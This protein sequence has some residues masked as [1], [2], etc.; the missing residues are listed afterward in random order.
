MDIILLQDVENLG[1][2]DDVVKVKPGYARNFLIPRNMA[3]VANR[4]NTK[5]LEEKLRQTELK[6]QKLLAEYK[7]QA[8]KIEGAT[9][10][11]G[12][13]VGTS[14]K[15]FGSITNIQVADAIKNT[16]GVE[17]DRKRL[18]LQDEIKSLGTYKARVEL[19]KDVSLEFDFE[20]IAE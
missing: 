20:V 2:K 17:V 7:A 12:A 5:A 1:Y 15:I 10:K 3:L 13:K 16:T 9:I 19:H 4:S 18:K 6:R 11:V 14:G 8:A